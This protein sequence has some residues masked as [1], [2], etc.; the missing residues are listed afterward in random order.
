MRPLV[1][2]SLGVV[3]LVSG[4][5]GYLLLKP[6]CACYDGPPPDATDIAAWKA[7]AA[8]DRSGVCPSIEA[9]DRRTD[10]WGTQLRLTC[11]EGTRQVTAWS[12]GADR[13]FDTRDDLRATATR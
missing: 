4:G 6:A 11:D 12:A 9:L 3:V 7:A 8:W 1:I 2:V 10:A 5:I 13:A